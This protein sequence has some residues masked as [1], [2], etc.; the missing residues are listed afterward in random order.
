[1]S[2]Q[3]VGQGGI[4]LEIRTH[5]WKLFVKLLYVKI[6]VINRL[7]CIILY[8]IVMNGNSWQGGSSDS[9]D[10]TPRSAWEPSVPSTGAGWILRHCTL[11]GIESWRRHCLSFSGNSLLDFKHYHWHPEVSLN[12]KRS[13]I[14]R[15]QQNLYWSKGG[16]EDWYMFCTIRVFVTSSIPS[17]TQWILD[18]IMIDTC[19]AQSM[20]SLL[21]ICLLQRRH[22]M[23]GLQS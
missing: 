12:N 23:E 15:K 6:F 2:A 10:F 1:M 22:Q 21:L 19:F 4:S 14:N 7:V 8:F 9:T 13:T 11:G 17:M 18:L 3:G 16:F 20:S 5:F